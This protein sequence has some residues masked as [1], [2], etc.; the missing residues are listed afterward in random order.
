MVVVSSIHHPST[1][2]S[3]IFYSIRSNVGRLLN[4]YRYRSYITEPAAITFH[5][6]AIL[7]FFKF[8]I[9]C[10]DRLFSLKTLVD[11]VRI[12]LSKLPDAHIFFNL[13]ANTTTPANGAVQKQ[14]MHSVE[15]QRETSKQI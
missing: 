7:I 15:A 13:C 10:F 14:R 6:A 2:S 11:Y 9:I 4:R 12:A 8:F 3:I 1:R 5:L